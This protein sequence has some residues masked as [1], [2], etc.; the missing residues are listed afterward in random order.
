MKTNRIIFL[1]TSIFDRQNYNFN[2]R[3]FTLLKEQFPAKSIKLLLPEPTE[4]EVE[5]HLKARVADVDKALRS[6]QSR[7]PFVVK[8]TGWPAAKKSPEEIQSELLDHARSDFNDFLSFYE[9]ERLGYEGIS[10]AKVMAAYNSKEPPFGDGSKRKEF[11]DAFVVEALDYYAAKN[12]ESVFV[13]SGDGDFEKA[14]ESRKYLKYFSSL[15]AFI[16]SVRE[17]NELI[18]KCTALL[19]KDNSKVAE[20]ICEAFE[21]LGF[22]LEEDWDADFSEIKAQG[23]EFNELNVIKSEG[24][25]CTVTFEALVSFKTDVSYDDYDSAV[26][27]SE[28]KVAI[29]LHRKE[30]EIYGAEDITGQIVVVLDNAMESIEAVQDVIIDQHTIE[31]SDRDWWD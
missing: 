14:C 16:T 8:L 26:W 25:K 4:Q 7:A 21:M 20:E 23:I 28:E 9:T 2:S 29:P 31:V 6:A 5:R 3:E 13:I 30:S 27:D 15:T 11:P 12:Q 17:E 1:D 18:S 10:I 24:K 19:E 22:V